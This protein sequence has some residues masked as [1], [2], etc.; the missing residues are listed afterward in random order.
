MQPRS[1]A[2][3]GIL[4]SHSPGWGCE[5][6]Y[7]VISSFAVPVKAVDYGVLSL[8]PHSLKR[9][10]P[11]DVKD[12]L[13]RSR[14]GWTNTVDTLTPGPRSRAP[15]LCSALTL[16]SYLQ[17]WISGLS[18]ILGS[19][20]CC[21]YQQLPVLLSPFFLTLPYHHL[22]CA[23][24]FLPFSVWPTRANHSL[25]CLCLF[26]DTSHCSYSRWQGHHLLRH[27]LLRA[28]PTSRRQFRRDTNHTPLSIASCFTSIQSSSNTS[29]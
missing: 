2:E 22:R 25:L 4:N 10:V 15:V 17:G 12:T 29:S 8:G 27:H 11:G 26:L 24:I 14:T 19:C 16:A 23:L 28:V 21:V 6:C 1:P 7:P 13:D 3:K 9:A 20:C 18:G 5:T